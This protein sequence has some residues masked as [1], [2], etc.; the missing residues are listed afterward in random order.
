MGAPDFQ[1]VIGE[2]SIS[3]A[4]WVRAS[5]VPGR[6]LPELTDEQKKVARGFKI[7][8]EEYAR[9]ELARLYGQERLRARAQQLGQLVEQM[10]MGIGSEYRLRAVTSEITKLRWILTVMAPEGPVNIFLPRSLVDD[11][12]D[13]QA[14]EVME[15]LRSRLM[16]GV[17]RDDPA[18]KPHR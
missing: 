14:R 7:S 18:A 9:A 12:L 16:Y 4:D 11:V 2:S 3:P 17:G 8:E 15:D 10:L 1:V 6:G 5:A 13:W